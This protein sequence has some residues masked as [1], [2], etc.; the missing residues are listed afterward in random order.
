MKRIAFLALLLPLAACSSGHTASSATLQNAE[1][2]RVSENAK[3]A[4]TASLGAPFKMDDLQLTVTNPV[5]GGNSGDAILTVTVKVENLGKDDANGFNPGIACSNSSDGGGYYADSTLDI[6]SG[7]PAKS[8]DTGTLGL[9]FDDK[10]TSCAAPAF[11]QF[12]P[13]VTVDGQPT[14]IRIPLDAALLA[15]LNARKTVAPS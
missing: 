9:N 15:A 8:I 2:A 13:Q 14:S 6:S 12:A 1:S 5:V 10:L 4:I 11:I 3:S 7:F